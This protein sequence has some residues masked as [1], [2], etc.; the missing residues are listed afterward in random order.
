M[1]HDVESA[2]IQKIFSNYVLHCESLKDDKALRLLAFDYFFDDM[3]SAFD[4][5]SQT[6]VISSLELFYE[7]SLLIKDVALDKAPWDSPWLTSLFQFE[8]D[9][10][11]IRIRPGTFIYD[12][13]D[14]REPTP[15]YSKG[16]PVALLSREE[17][18]QNLSQLLSERLDSR[19]K[20]KDDILSPL[21]LFDP[22]IQLVL[23]GT[24]RS[25]HSA[26]HELNEAWFNRRARFH[27]QHIIILDCLYTFSPLDNFPTRVKKQR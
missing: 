22:C 13:R 14:T 18:T 10:E 26:C 7:Y 9:G 11:G 4:T 17:F 12:N 25:E 24:C 15:E 23:H 6:G 8:K 20:D 27:L 1:F 3:S 2:S 5:S 19:I 21:H 16:H